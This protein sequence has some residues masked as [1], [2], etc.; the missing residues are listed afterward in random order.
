M[1]SG[2]N[3]LMVNTRSTSG[4]KSGSGFKGA[5]M[6][7]LDYEV[8]PTSGIARYAMRLEARHPYYFGNCFPD[9][10]LFIKFIRR[11]Y[12]SRIRLLEQ[13]CARLRELEGS[14]QHPIGWVIGEERGAFRK[15]LRFYVLISGVTDFRLCQKWGFTIAGRLVKK[16][17]SWSDSHGTALFLAKQAIDRFH[18]GGSLLKDHSDT[19]ERLSRHTSKVELKVHIV[20]KGY[21]PDRSGSGYGYLI[22]NTGAK[23]VEWRDG[24]TRNEA[25][26][27]GILRAVNEV[28]DG[29]SMRIMTNSQ[30][31]VDHFAENGEPHYRV[32]RI[33]ARIAWLSKQRRL[34]VTAEWIPK[35]EN[36]ARDLLR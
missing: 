5:D 30:A 10:I 7:E 31:I 18:F 3:V 29:S 19:S 4:N 1:P 25:I 13:I 34:T 27:H 32:C 11:P 21:A 15:L 14:V 9:L 33:W 12:A 17:I 2:Q 20:G 35:T 26:Y 22:E 16:R 6:K 24:W 36:L 23:H 8:V 28:P